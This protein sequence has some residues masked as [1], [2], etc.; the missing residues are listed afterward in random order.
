MKIREKHAQHLKKQ[1]SIFAEEN[2]TMFIGKIGNHLSLQQNQKIFVIE[3]FHL[4]S[5][6]FWLNNP[7]ADY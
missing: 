7:T 6:C 4:V 1:T 5:L 2:C 3:C